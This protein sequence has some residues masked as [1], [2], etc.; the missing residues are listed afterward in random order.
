MS[1]KQTFLKK[2]YSQCTPN[3]SEPKYQ[4][5]NGYYE[6][7]EVLIEEALSLE[8]ENKSHNLFYPI[9]YSYRH[10]IELHLKTIIVDLEKLYMLSEELGFLKNGNLLEENR[11]SEKLHETHSLDK[12]LKYT[13]ERVFFTQVNDEEFPKEIAKYIRQFH[14]KDKSGQSFRYSKGTSGKSSFET[15]PYY[16]LGVLRSTMKEVNKILWAVDSHCDFYLEAA[17][18]I[19]KEMEA[20]Y[21]S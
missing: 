14:E 13:E 1:K 11:V 12:L 4:Y 9:C 3:Y 20:E 2:D 15:T 18:S 21:S 10:Y 5:I 6:A 17:K 8:A 16:E 7:A 19:T